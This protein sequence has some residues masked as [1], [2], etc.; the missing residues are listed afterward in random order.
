MP[1][2]GSEGAVICFVASAV[3]VTLNLTT[4]N[5]LDFKVS[6]TQGISSGSDFKGKP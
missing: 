5:T 1:C 6:F 3:H 2:L 4:P